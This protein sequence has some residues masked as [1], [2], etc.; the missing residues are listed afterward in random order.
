MIGFKTDDITT[1]LIHCSSRK[2][3]AK[4]VITDGLLIGYRPAFYLSIYK[5]RRWIYSRQIMKQLSAG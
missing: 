4:A 5:P 3:G 1:A 2:D